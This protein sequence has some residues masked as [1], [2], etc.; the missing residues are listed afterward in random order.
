MRPGQ[1][2]ERFHSTELSHSSLV[3]QLFKVFFL[4]VLHFQKAYSIKWAKKEK[5]SV[6][7]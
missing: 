7:K 1:H 5:Y 6:E 4:K 2:T 3:K